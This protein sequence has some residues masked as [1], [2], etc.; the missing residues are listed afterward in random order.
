MNLEADDHK[1]GLSGWAAHHSNPHILVV[2]PQTLTIVTKN[3]QFV[4]YV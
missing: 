4:M 1:Q 2:Y 3:R